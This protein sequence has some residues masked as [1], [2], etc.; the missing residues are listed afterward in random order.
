MQ[1]RRS[2]FARRISVVG[3]GLA[4][5]ACL[6]PAA[7]RAQQAD[8]ADGGF[9]DPF[10]NTNREIFKFNQQVDRMVLVPVAKAYRA[11]LPEPVRDS[12]HNIL[13]NLDSPVVFANDV[14][15]GRADL[16]SDTLGRFLANSTLG[17]GG[18][19]D[20]ATAAHVPYHSNDLGITFA[21]WGVGEGPYLMLPILGPS[22]V[23]DAIG[24]AGDSYG[25]PANIVA[26][27]NHLLWATFARVGVQG[28]DARAR[29]IET[30]ND[31]ERTSLDYY[32]TI[33]SLYR[34]RRAA[35]IRHEKSS[36]PSVSPLGDDGGGGTTASLP[37][38]PAPNPEIPPI[39]YSYAPG[40]PR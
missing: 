15:Q 39:S 13:R 4:M 20:V 30:L 1:F 5:L 34:Q 7:A 24:E 37:A 12:I 32:A 27:N 33:R 38:S 36:V 25:D 9:N 16:A 17:V 35:E 6:A 11:A 29:N 22:D 26:T 3:I 8:P 40:P 21:V 2:T 19:F 10:E 28:V 31:I 23:R 18:M 14:L